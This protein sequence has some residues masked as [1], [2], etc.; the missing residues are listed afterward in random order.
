MAHMMSWLKDQWK[1][2]KGN[3]K[4]DLF[5]KAFALLAAAIIYLLY[6]LRDWLSS[7]SLPVKILSGALLICVVICFLLLILLNQARKRPYITITDSKGNAQTSS[8]LL[9]RELIDAR[10]KAKVSGTLT[11][12]R[13]A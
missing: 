1:D 5:K 2:V 11:I 10:G 9:P 12:N 6:A 3:A 7:L 8:F 4:W 13:L